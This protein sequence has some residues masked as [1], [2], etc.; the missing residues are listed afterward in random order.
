MA[1][2]AA[3][4][5]ALAAVTDVEGEA[6]GGRGVP[7][8]RPTERGR[9]RWSISTVVIEALQPRRRAVSGV[10]RCPPRVQRPSGSMPS[11]PVA[12]ELADVDEQDQVPASTLG[13]GAVWPR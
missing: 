6:L 3:G 7:D 2:G 13:E 8:R 11:W 12:V 9:P 1:A 10:M 5:A 4:V